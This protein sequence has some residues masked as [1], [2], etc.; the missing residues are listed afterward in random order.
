MR[1]LRRFIVYCALQVSCPVEKVNR[2]WLSSVKI[3]LHY[4]SQRLSVYMYIV[5][6]TGAIPQPFLD[7]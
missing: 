3:Q 4:K 5:T 7:N 6:E 2:Q 1:K